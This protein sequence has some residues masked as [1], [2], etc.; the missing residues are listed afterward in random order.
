[1]HTFKFLWI[2]TPVLWLFSCSGPS[3]S[4]Q[5]LT[6]A[7]SLLAVQTQEIEKTNL[8][9]EEMIKTE[10]PGLVYYPLESESHFHLKKRGGISSFSSKSNSEI[11]WNLLFVNIDSKEQHLL[12]EDSWGI[13]QSFQ[14]PADFI[15]SE[16]GAQ[17][18]RKHRKFRTGHLFY[19]IIT[20]DYNADDRLTTFDPSYLYQSNSFGKNLR[21][22]SPPN[23]D[24]R[25]WAFIDSLNFQIELRG[26]VDRNNDG[27]FNNEDPYEVWFAELG[28]SVQLTPLLTP[29]ETDSLKKIYLD[30]EN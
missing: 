28:D 3:E 17:S 26:H 27:R 10:H 16:E 29:A 7:D 18:N 2:L 20:E 14:E 21:L 4:D 11:T 15:H 24:V 6:K 23:M 19:K 30:I 8:S 5:P 1:M 13:I 22:I 12:L 25:E 9:V